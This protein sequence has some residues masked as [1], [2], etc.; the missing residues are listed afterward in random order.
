MRVKA[1]LPLHAN[2]PAH[3]FYNIRNARSELTKRYSGVQKELNRFIKSLKSIRV[4]NAVNTYRQPNEIERSDRD[5]WSL[6]LPVLQT[7]EYIY[8]LDARRYMEINDFIERLL[9]KYLLDYELSQNTNRFWLTANVRNAYED[10]LTD[11]VREVNI[12]ANAEEL[13]EETQMRMRQLTTESMLNSQPVQRRLSLIYARVFN[14]MKG[15]C[16]SS[17]VDLS[18]TL[19]RA[20]ADGVGITEI[21]KRIKRRLEVSSGRAKRIA[22]TEIMQAFRSANTD[23]VRELNETLTQDEDVEFSFLWFSALADT[24][25]PNHRAQHG[26]IR[27][28]K[29]IKEFYS[30]GANAINCLCSQR[31]I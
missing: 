27:N 22:R 15:L 28:R 31:P 3:Q 14:E 11:I 26:K 21:T 7:N 5:R 4:Q 12:S 13:S 16:D 9:Y 6:W 1:I 20:M 19:T 18:D 10:A 25:R 2:D 23:E 8:E 29:W 30:K 17:K 24:T